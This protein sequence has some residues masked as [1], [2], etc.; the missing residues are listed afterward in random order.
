MIA[1]G[2]LV[3]TRGPALRRSRDKFLLA[4][5]AQRGRAREGENRHANLLTSQPAFSAT[6]GGEPDRNGRK[7]STTLAIK[8]RRSDSLSVPEILACTSTDHTRRGTNRAFV[9]ASR[10]IFLSLNERCRAGARYLESLFGGA[11]YVVPARELVAIRPVIWGQRE[12]LSRI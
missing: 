9:A 1:G 2:M 7:I 12:A 6:S 4:G 8:A 5:I 3:G 10:T 11:Q